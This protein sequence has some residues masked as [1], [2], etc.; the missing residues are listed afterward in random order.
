MA[1]E[2]DNLRVDAI[3]LMSQITSHIPPNVRFRI[4]NVNKGLEP[5]YGQ[6][7]VVH[8]RCVGS[9]IESYRRLL[10][11]ASKCLKPGGVAIFMEG[12]F[13]LWAENRE[14]L[15]VPASDE[16]PNGSWLQRWMQGKPD[17]IS[18]AWIHA[19]CS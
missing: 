13:D 5:Y 9:G 15:Q 4:H 1:N 2:Y 3:D 6:Y 8:M 18:L 11:E 7:D 19:Y 12:D 10:V 16:N 14:T 17:S